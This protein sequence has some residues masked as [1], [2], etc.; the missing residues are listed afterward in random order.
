MNAAA[1]QVAD[2][3]RSHPGVK[4]RRIA[5]ETHLPEE[6]V[7]HVLAAFDDRGIAVMRR[8]ESRTESRG[9]VWSL[10]GKPLLPSDMEGI[11]A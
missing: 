1:H 5:S 6:E 4:A 2:Y 10:T 11:A 3:L 9:F 8:V 7:Y